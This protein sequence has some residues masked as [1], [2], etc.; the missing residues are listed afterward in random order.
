M[1]ELALFDLDHTLI[2][3]DSSQ[4]WGRYMMQQDMAPEGFAARLDQFQEDYVAGTLDMDAYL[5]YFAAPLANY[6]RA[7]LDQW[8]E[9]FMDAVV[10]PQIT[11]EARQLVQQHLDAGHLCGIVTATIDFVTRPIAREFGV[12]HLLAITLETRNG[13][14]DGAYTGGWV[15]IPTFREGKVTRSEMWLQDMGLNW[16][17]FA[18]IHFYSDSMND[19]PLL[20]H[21]SHPVATNPDARL[22]TLAE[23]EGWPIIQ[24][25]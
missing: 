2:P 14:E 10:R 11:P 6:S 4:E 22:K 3:F 17:S 12:A 13:Q 19:L 20:R 25:F 7:E 23:Q 21:A 18:A 8:H 24:L 5:R 1:T 16:D 15:G 9:R